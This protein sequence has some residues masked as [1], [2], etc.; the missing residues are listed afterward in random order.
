MSQE[1]DQHLRTLG[2][3]RLPARVYR[4]LL[5][6]GPRPAGDIG[7]ALNCP[8][9]AVRRSIGELRDLGLITV[10]DPSGMV[11]SI[12]DPTAA[13]RS[14]GAKLELEIAAG[15]DA[16][17]AAYER[18]RR[19]HASP[20]RGVGVEILHGSEIAKRV[21]ELEGSANL[22]VRGL[23]TAPYQGPPWENPVEIANLQRG[24]RYRILYAKSSI[25]T[26][27]FYQQNIVPCIKAGEVARCAPSV[28]LKMFLVDGVVAMVSLA[29]DRADVRHTAM[30]VR[31][32]HLLSALSALFDF[33][34]QS[35][36]ALLQKDDLRCDLRPIE[37]L[38]L[39]QLA[40]GVSDQAA[41]RNLRI[42][43]RTVARYVERLMRLSGATS[44]FQLAIYAA[45]HGWLD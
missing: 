3:A 5:E 8:E 17:V 14:R 1:L 40:I 12:L 39:R 30:E 11:R 13:L 18:H 10:D 37:T 45:N 29:V 16:S 28:P 15:I 25:E 20:S 33:A 35:A 22:E 27:S 19:N 34:W 6:R 26:P 38:L 32:D 41:A 36:T 9:T 7:G 4:D 42:S 44:R 2:I 31:S 24:I 23:D 21:A 43:S